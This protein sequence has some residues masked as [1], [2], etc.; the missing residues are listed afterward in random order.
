M[1]T[2]NQP[3]DL[4]RALASERL[5]GAGRAGWE[6]IR[7]IS[8]SLRDTYIMRRLEDDAKIPMKS[9]TKA[10]LNQLLLPLGIEGHQFSYDRDGRKVLCVPLSDYEAK[11]APRLAE[12]GPGDLAYRPD[13]NAEL[14]LTNSLDALMTQRLREV[15]FAA[16]KH[17]WWATT[18]KE[19]A[20]C[21]V[22]SLLSCHVLKDLPVPVEHLESLAKPLMQEVLE[23]DAIQIHEDA[24]SIDFVLSPE[25]YECMQSKLSQEGPGTLI[26][27]VH[28]IGSPRDTPAH[29]QQR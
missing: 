2:D 11:I 6:S 14:P 22:L 1:T 19:G 8:N 16:P 27:N 17:L 29:E 23:C 20:P 25:L 18:D 3:H 28:H 12:H 15:I 13:P 21:H 10:A 5:F 4:H 26:G 24:D 7:V 9:A